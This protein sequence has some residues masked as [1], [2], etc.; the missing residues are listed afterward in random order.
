MITPEAFIFVWIITL[1]AVY[2]LVLVI[3]GIAGAFRRIRAITT[4]KGKGDGNGRG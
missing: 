4:R 3:A 1:I 2:L